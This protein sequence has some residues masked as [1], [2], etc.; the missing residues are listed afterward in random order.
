MNCQKALQARK[1]AGLSDRHY[2]HIK[3][4]LAPHQPTSASR[5]PAFF[6]LQAATNQ[7]VTEKSIAKRA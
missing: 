2:G 7:M 5:P 1:N 3:S 4:K 6:W